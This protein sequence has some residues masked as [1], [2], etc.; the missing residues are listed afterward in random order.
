MS[1]RPLPLNEP[2]AY[3]DPPLGKEGRQEF[4]KA[5]GPHGKGGVQLG[6]PKAAW[7]EQQSWGRS[8]QPTWL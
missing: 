2:G 1:V 4:T 7:R 6:Y 5:S 3:R 8:C